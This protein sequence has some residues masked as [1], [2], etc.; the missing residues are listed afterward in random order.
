MYV[1]V[2]HAA[3]NGYEKPVDSLLKLRDSGRS[4]VPVRRTVTGTLYGCSGYLSAQIAG[5]MR[6]RLLH[7]S[8]PIG[9]A[10]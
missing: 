10:Q 1:E 5:G 8:A 6:A 4:L 2:P 9:V 7:S 3:A